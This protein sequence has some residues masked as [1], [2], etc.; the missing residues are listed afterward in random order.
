MKIEMMFIGAIFFGLAFVV[1]LGFLGDG[2]SNY[3]VDADTSSTFGKMSNDIKQIYD[4]QDSMKEQ[5]QGGVVTDSD[6]VDQMLRGG[7]TSIRGN[8]FDAVSVA[9][10]AS[11]NLAKETGF[12]PADII[13]FLMTTMAILLLFAIIALIFKFEQR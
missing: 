1:G 10:N 3:N 2:L 12:L 7:Y 9:G 4:Y 6:A 11:M 5:I 13:F 8:P